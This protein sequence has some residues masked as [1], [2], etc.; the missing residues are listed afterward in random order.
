[1][2]EADELAELRTTSQSAM[3]DSC[4]VARPDY[5][6]ATLNT[7]TGLYDV[8]D[9]VSVYEGVC[10]IRPDTGTPTVTRAGDTPTTVTTYVVTVPDDSGPFEIGDVVS[11]TVSD[12]PNI[13]NRSFRVTDVP[14]GSWQIDQRLRCEQL[15]DRG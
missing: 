13:A 4:V 7:T 6:S 3:P 9:P 8:P 14:A 15:V 10:R 11:I 2:I 1:M 5:P 12:D